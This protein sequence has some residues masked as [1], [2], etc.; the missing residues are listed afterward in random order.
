MFMLLARGAAAS[1][2][3]LRRPRTCSARRPSTAATWGQAALSCAAASSRKASRC[4]SGRAVAA[5]QVGALTALGGMLLRVEARH[6]SC[7]SAVALLLEEL[8]ELPAGDMCAMH[9]VPPHLLALNW[10]RP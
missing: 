5:R 10:A 6:S 7:Y 2:A 9:V 8:E 3:S 4:V 1:R